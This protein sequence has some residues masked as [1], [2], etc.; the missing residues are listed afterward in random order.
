[1]TPSWNQTPSRADRDGLV[2]ELAG[3]LRA[4][5]HVD[6]VDRER[7]VGQGGVA[8]LAEHAALGEAAAG[9]I[10]T[11]CLPRSWSS[12]AIEYAVRLGS[13]ESPTTAQV[14]Q[15]SSMN[16]IA[17]GSCQRHASS[18]ARAVLDESAPT[19]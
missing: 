6:H 5:E 16:R 17:S 12:A 14:L 1:M 15:S 10:G 13:P 18:S 8:L 9:W 7:H 4:P 2:G 19:M 11:I 3:G